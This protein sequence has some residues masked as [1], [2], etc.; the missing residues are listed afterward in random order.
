MI[1]AVLSSKY[2]LVI[3]KPIR[4]QLGL[5]SSQKI[6]FLVKDG[7]I[8][9]I[10]EKPLKESRGFLKDMNTNGLREHRERV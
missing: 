4:K 6:G 8:T 5:R 3:P 7:M 2:Q 9:L 10:P 1:G